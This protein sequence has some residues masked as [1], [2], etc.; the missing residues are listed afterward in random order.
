MSDAELTIRLCRSGN[1]KRCCYNELLMHLQYAAES[2]VPRSASHPVIACSLNLAKKGT[3]SELTISLFLFG[4]WT[5]FSQSEYRTS[6][7]EL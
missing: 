3:H 2:D 4:G 1:P 5:S 6:F 7:N